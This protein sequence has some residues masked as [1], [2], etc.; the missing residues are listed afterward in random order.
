MEIVDKGA[1][2]HLTLSIGMVSRQFSLENLPGRTN[3]SYA[4][5]PGDGLLFRGNEAG[6]PFGGP[7]ADVGDKVGCGIKFT[8]VQ[9]QGK[10]AF[11]IGG[12]ASG[13]LFFTHNSKEVGSTPVNIPPGGYFPA[14]S[15]TDCLSVVTRCGLRYIQEEDIMMMV[16]NCDDDWL[17]LHDI[18][19][20][21][22]VLEYI[23]MYKGGSCLRRHLSVNF[24]PAQDCGGLEN[25]VTR[26]S[27]VCIVFLRIVS[28]TILLYWRFRVFYFI[29]SNYCFRNYF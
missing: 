6:S 10:N 13:Q 21:G 26:M 24:R 4:F 16:D 9:S 23:G 27:L 8:P 3:E 14:F 17:N 28:A 12:A 22:P 20:N 15:M 1:A 19:L 7:R 29:K 11:P 2:T 25:D 5:C 18:R